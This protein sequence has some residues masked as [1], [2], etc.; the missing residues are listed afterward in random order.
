[1]AKETFTFQAEVG[2]ILDIVAHS[3]YSEKEVFLR[4]LI[5]NSSDAC[6]KLRYAT[7]TDS[8]LAKDTADFKIEIDL[9]KKEKTIT[10]SDNGIGM[11]RD[12][13]VESL[14]TIAKS[15]TQA[16]MESLEGKDDKDVQ[17]S[18]IGQF[19]VGFYSAF[20]VADNITVISKKA[21]SSDA[22]SWKSD[23]K[24]SFE[25]DESQKGNQ[26]TEVILNI[27]DKDKEFL[28]PFRIESV[29]KKYSDHI[30]QPV[31]LKPQKKGEEDKVLNNASALWTR[32]KKDISAEQYKEF[33]HHVGM[34]YDDPWLTLHNKA[35][36]LI[37][38]TNLLFIPSTRPFDIFNPD[39]KS[40]LKLYVRRVFITDD[41]EGLIPPYLRFVKGV[42]DTDDIDLNVSREM[43]QNNPVVAK[44][45]SAIIK[46]II[47]ELKKKAN[48]DP[49][50]YAKFWEA[51]GAVLK[52]GIHEDFT[53]RD[54]ILEV[55]RFKSSE[56]DKYTSLEEYITRMKK[57]QDKIYYISGEDVEKLSQ[58][59]HLE[60]FKAK[61]IEVL[62]MTDP[63][64]EFWLPSVGKYSEKD[65]QSITKGGADLDKIKT[66]KK[67]TKEKDKKNNKSIDKLVASIK[68]ALGDEVKEVKASER[69]TDSAVCLVAG[70]GDMDMHLEKLLKQ[71][72]QIDK[73][74]QKVLEINP[75]HPLISDLL[76]ILD[77][78]KEKNLFFDDASWLLLD[79]AKIMEGQPVS[80]P[81]KF[82]RRMNALMQRGIK[83]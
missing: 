30:A 9:N 31:I 79:Q 55:S 80:D 71:H 53:N 47:S 82:A 7:I 76:K 42:I 15:G 1:M 36:G 43:L 22:W 52:E 21:G 83:I 58:S 63:V 50:D 77:N 46:R 54:K 49:E 34:A 78:E 48:K 65:F 60:G 19:G 8:K 25:V 72:Q 6:D 73:T 35:E 17:S 28:D 20:M 57:G 10:I 16:F 66:G 2:K 4:E 67:D 11:T 3:L 13:M 68:V 29:V 56:A 51:F 12:E 23:G 74:S 61:G 18:L 24:G 5:S 59:P 33:Y 70:E 39:R 37:S 32:D 69:L 14:G 64:D 40:N 27:S 45:K 62:F 41:C 38:Y 26:G 75:S 81:S 44:I